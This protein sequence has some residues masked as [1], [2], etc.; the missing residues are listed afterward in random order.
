MDVPRVNVRGVHEKIAHRRRT[1][2]GEIVLG[3]RGNGRGE[4]RYG[5][6]RGTRQAAHSSTRQ[7]GGTGLGLSVARQR[8][9]LLGGEV[10]A[11]GAPGVGSTFTV[12]LPRDAGPAR[13]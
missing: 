3:H 7:S 13:G 12:V 1:R 9:E 8:A 2:E 5:S 10:S 4:D 11:L 6:A